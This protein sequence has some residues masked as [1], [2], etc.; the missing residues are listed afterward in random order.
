M[1]VDASEYNY[2]TE[3]MEYVKS[4][5]DMLPGDYSLIATSFF[6]DNYAVKARLPFTKYKSVAFITGDERNQ[7]PAYLDDPNL[8][9]MFKTCV[10]AGGLHPKLLP[11]PLG[12]YRRFNPTRE[13]P[14]LERS[15]DLTFFSQVTCPQ[16]QEMVD[17]VE[18][19]VKNR[20]DD[21]T[22]KPVTTF[23]SYTKSYAA[24]EVGPYSE[25]MNDTKIALNPSPGSNV[26]V[27]STRFFEGMAAGCVIMSTSRPDTWFY[28]GAPYIPI[29]NW[30]D[31]GPLIDDILSDPERMRV[32]S[33]ASY[34][35]W[36]HICCPR[37]VGQYV[38]EKIRQLE[39]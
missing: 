19:Y 30:K 35:W 27:D 33:R 31:A 28:D 11:L 26:T 4:E 29:D 34:A 10:P 16:R 8:A 24:G 21:S 23:L 15:Y 9:L 25:I 32:M 39:K 7:R 12:T 14:I 38:I 20:N 3:I 5:E 36:D 22:R 2:I 6:G 17:A 37:A 1:G 18:M 13:Y